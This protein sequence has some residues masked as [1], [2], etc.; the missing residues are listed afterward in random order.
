MTNELMIVVIDL[1]FF[2][3]LLP[4]LYNLWRTKDAEG[5][6]LWTSIPTAAMLTALI[7]LFWP[8]NVAIAL[9][10]V[11]GGIC[12]A[13]VAWMTWKFRRRAHVPRFTMEEYRW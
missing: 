6:S 12:W 10:H 13:A 3:M 8:I 5:H 11:P 2:M 1:I 7:P 9:A 4:T